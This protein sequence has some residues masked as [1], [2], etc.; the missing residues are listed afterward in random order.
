MLGSKG[1]SIGNGIWTIKW[2]RT[3]D[4]KTVTPKGAVMQYGPLS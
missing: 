3:D 2:S 4:V 1:P